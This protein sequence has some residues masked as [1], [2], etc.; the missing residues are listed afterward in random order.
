MNELATVDSSIFEK[1]YL[2]P[3]VAH[4]M[5]QLNLPQV[6]TTFGPD[7][8]CS[9]YDMSRAD[10][11][12][13]ETLPEFRKLLD[14]MQAK[15]SEL[16]SRAS[17]ILKTEAMTADL[18]EILYNKLRK[19]PAIELKDFIAGVNTIAKAAGLDAPPKA[20]EVAAGQNMAIQ[21]VI[22]QLDNPKLAFLEAAT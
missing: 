8:I 15:A 2:W 5:V 18:L 19:D 13:L 14:Q 16:G 1:R 9:T 17:F 12:R 3:N 20:K 22:P 21:I 10:M 11:S 7:D 4:D 6:G